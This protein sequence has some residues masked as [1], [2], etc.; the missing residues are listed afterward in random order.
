MKYFFRMHLRC[1]ETRRS[2]LARR[3]QKE[4]RASVKAVTGV[5]WLLSNVTHETAA[6]V[7]L[8]HRHRHSK[9]TR[10]PYSGW[11]WSN[12]SKDP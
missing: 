2:K 4:G 8:Q 7:R 10:A 5:C 9:C 12:L 11:R 1:D 6:A 3:W